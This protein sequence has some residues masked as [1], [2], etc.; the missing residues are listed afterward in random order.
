MYYVKLIAGTLLLMALWAAFVFFTAFYGWWMKPIASPGET[1]EFFQWASLELQSKNAG[2]SALLLIDDGKV[3]ADYY[4]SK[5]GAIDENTVFQT[6][7]M[8]KW[9]T[10]NAVMKLVQDGLIDLDTPVSNYLTRWTLPQGEFD[11][12]GVTTRRL[13]SHT[14]GLL[15]DLGFGD[16]D[17]EEEIPTLVQSLSNPRASDN[18]LVE[19]TVGIEP[20]SAWRYSGGGY[21]ILQLLIEEVTGSVFREYMAETFFKPLEMTRSSYS[22][23]GSVE[24]NAGSY[25]S[26]GQAAP[27]YQYASDAATGFITSSADLAR[28]VIAQ[29]SGPDDTYTLNQSTLQMMRQPHGRTSGIDIWGLGTILYAPTGKGDYVFGHDGANDPAINSAAR[30]NP[31]NRDAIIVLA[32]GSPS[33]ATNIGSQ[34]VLWQT[35]YP[36]VLNS[37]SVIESMYQPL[38]VGLLILMLV[39]VYMGRRFARLDNNR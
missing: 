24:N 21:L 39:A 26:S 19:I 36:D 29:M 14:A 16:Y 8:S 7:S 17:S 9:L 28:F 38:L 37:G 12:D 10:A 27:I 1:E 34:W 35:G 3:L 30:I 11:N 5:Q 2:V 22:F 33:I 4:S 23:M 13:L 15:D 31:D 6:A 32:T 20:G 18:R 25:E